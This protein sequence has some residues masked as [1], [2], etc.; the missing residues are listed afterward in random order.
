M[1]NLIGGDREMSCRIGEVMSGV[2]PG[3]TAV[4]QRYMAMSEEGRAAGTVCVGVCVCTCVWVCALTLKNKHTPLS[5]LL[6]LAA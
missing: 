4:P 2:P 1:R 3:Q 5:P 6:P